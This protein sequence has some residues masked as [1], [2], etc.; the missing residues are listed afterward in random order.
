MWR[1]ERWTLRRRRSPA[2]L[3]RDV[4]TRWRR[5]SKRESL[6]ILL[7]LAFF[8]EDILAAILD[9]LALIGLGLAP[10]ADLG[11]ELADALAGVAPDLDPGRIPGLYLQPLR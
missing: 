9:A 2:R 4:R 8:A 5:R 7:L 10:A 3:R 11:R 6:A 1:P